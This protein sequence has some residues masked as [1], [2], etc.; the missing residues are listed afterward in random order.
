M[1]NRVRPSRKRPISHAT[2]RPRANP[3]PDWTRNCSAASLQLNAPVAAAAI[4]NLNATRPD[5]SLMRLSPLSA[6]VTRDGTLSLDVIALTDTASVGE[7]T[8]PSA[9]AADSGSDGISQCI[10]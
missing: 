4:A 5:A 1:Q 6:V 10:R 2:A 7:I 3:P 8:A 9:N